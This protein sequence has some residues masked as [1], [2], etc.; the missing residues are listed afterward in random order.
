MIDDGLFCQFPCDESYAVHSCRA[1]RKGTC[2]ADDAAMMAALATFEI[3]I[4]GRAAPHEGAGRWS[5]RQLLTAVQSI[6]SG[7]MD[8]QSAAVISAT[9]L[10]A[11]S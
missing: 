5:P 8:P 3:T 4:T 2:V 6:V 11:T 7:N 9:G 1:C 10:P